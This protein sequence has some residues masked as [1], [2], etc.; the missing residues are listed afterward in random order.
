MSEQ[1]ALMIIN[2]MKDQF[3]ALA[4]LIYDNLADDGKIDTW[5]GFQI[6]MQAL[7]TGMNLVNLL[8][9]MP[10]EQLAAILHVLEHGHWTNA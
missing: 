4:R 9:N 1:M 3:T 10:K 7:P 8:K 2:Q 5:E 6:G